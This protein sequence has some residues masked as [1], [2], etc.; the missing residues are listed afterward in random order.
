MNVRITRIKRYFRYLFQYICIEKPRGLDFTMRDP[1]IY[2]KSGGRYHGYSKTDESHLQTI[3]ENLSY[4]KC[5]RFLDVGCGKGV[6][7]KEALKYPFQKV[8]GIELQPELVKIA[9]KNL[10][11]LHLSERAECIHANALDYENYGDFDA[12]FFL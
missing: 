9:N 4:E 2:N 12:Y 10:K 8:S 5:H 6:V 3:F 7:L 1:R 11:K